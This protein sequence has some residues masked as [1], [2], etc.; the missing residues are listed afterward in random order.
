[1]SATQEVMDKPTELEALTEGAVELL[2]TDKGSKNKA[3]DK[4]VKNEDA[5][6]RGRLALDEIHTRL[7]EPYAGLIAAAKAFG[8]IGEEMDFIVDAVKRRLD[9]FQKRRTLKEP[10]NTRGRKGKS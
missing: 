1:M 6:K 10:E 8:E 5:E 7:G 9:V 4:K 3:P 2:P